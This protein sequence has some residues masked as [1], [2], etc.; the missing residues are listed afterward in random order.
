MRLALGPLGPLGPLAFIG[1]FVVMLIG[2]IMLA[3][4][5]QQKNNIAK[6]KY[7]QTVEL[8]GG[9]FQI[10]DRCTG[11]ITE[12]S[13]KD[14]TEG[15]YAPWY[16]MDIKCWKGLKLVKDTEKVVNKRYLEEELVKSE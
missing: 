15:V 13:A 12:Y 11:V 3:S 5:V 8:T 9:Q 6:F 2:V 16:R 14:K 10:Y 4:N 1:V 7:G